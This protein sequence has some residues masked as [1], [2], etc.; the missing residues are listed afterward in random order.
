MMRWQTFVLK[1]SAAAFACAFFESFT[2]LFTQ[3]YSVFSPAAGCN[4][5]TS[6]A[7]FGGELDCVVPQ[8]S[9]TQGFFPPPPTPA[10]NPAAPPTPPPSIAMPSSRLTCV[11]DETRNATQNATWSCVP[12]DAPENAWCREAWP[13]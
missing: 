1:F 10:P 9:D 8:F 7:V 5:R 3:P 4:F 11:F 13:T 6:V 2:E 12:P